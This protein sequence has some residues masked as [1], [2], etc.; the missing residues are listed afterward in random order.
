MWRVT[1]NKESC[2]SQVSNDKTD[3]SASANKM[4]G[5]MS[6]GKRQRMKRAA[7]HEKIKATIFDEVETVNSKH[8]PMFGYEVGLLTGGHGSSYNLAAG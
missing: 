6:H 1:S 3:S 4:Q 7:N 5:Q 8:E 2:G